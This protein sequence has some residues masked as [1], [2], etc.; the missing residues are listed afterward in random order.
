MTRTQG[1]GDNHVWW[2]PRMFRTAGWTPYGEADGSR[3]VSR[4]T[5]S[6]DITEPVLGGQHIRMHLVAIRVYRDEATGVQ[7][8]VNAE[9]EEELDNFTVAFNPDGGWDTVEIDGCDYVIFAEPYSP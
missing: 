1:E 9:H 5:A 4:M 3:S 6:L 7:H 2:S 8:A